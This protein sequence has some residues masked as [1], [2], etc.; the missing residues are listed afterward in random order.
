MLLSSMLKTKCN[1]CGGLTIDHRPLTIALAVD[2]DKLAQFVYDN[3]NNDNLIEPEV[4]KQTAN[5]L[6]DGFK[7]GYGTSFEKMGAPGVVAKIQNNLFKFS[8]A[9]TFTQ[10][11]EMRD[12]VVK[13]GEVQSAGDFKKSVASI[14]DDFNETYLETEYNNVVA[15]G[16]MADRWQDIAAAR[17]LYPNLKYVTAGDSRVRPAHAILDGKILPVNDAFWNKYYPPNGWNCRCTVEQMDNEAP[18]D[19]SKETGKLAK[20]KAEVAP[21]FQNNVGKSGIVFKDNHPYFL[22]AAGQLKNLNYKSYGLKPFDEIQGRG[23]S[24][25]DFDDIKDYAQWIKGNE[26]LSMFDELPLTIDEQAANKQA[27]R[28]DGQHWEVTPNLH[29]V[30]GNPDES[31]QFMDPKRKVLTRSAFKYF[32]DRN[33]ISVAEL[34]EDKGWTIQ[35]WYEWDKKSPQDALRLGM[36]MAKK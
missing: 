27:Q 8:A 14:K 13:D 19:D 28:E 12:L 30:W 36:L 23:E 16:Q 35:T 20:D 25:E 2:A 21:L 5:Q 11:N 34:N 24:T 6:W 18:V 1:V 26:Q 7:S 29:A 33:I 32:K 22:N 17:D 4:Y 15:S 9:K 31:F 10:M 3:R